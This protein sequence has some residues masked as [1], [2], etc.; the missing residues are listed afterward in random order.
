MTQDPY[1]PHKI[2]H[3]QDVIN[4]L[5][6]NIHVAPIQVQLIISDLCNQ[7]CKFCAYRL[8]NYTSNQLFKTID[9]ITHIINNNPNRMIPKDKCFEIL[10][11]CVEI[12]TKAIQYTGG[13]EPTVHPNHIEIFQK[14]LDLGLDLALVTNG[15]ILRKE[16]PEILSHG[17]WVRISVDCSNAQSYSYIRNVSEKVFYRVL[18]NISC[19][20]KEREK[21]KQSELIIGVGFVVNKDN[22]N[23]IYDAVK[24]S[25]D[26][27][28]DNIRISAAFTVE[29]YHYHDSYYIVARD[30]ARKAKEDFEDSNFKVFNLFGDRIQDLIDQKP[31]YDFCAYMYL[32]TYI[33]GDLNV[34]RCCN[35]A[36]NE[37]GLIGSIKDKRFKDFWFSEDIILKYNSFNATSCERCMFNN[38]NRFINYVLEKKPLHVN[39]I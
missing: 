19:I 4:K 12:G 23:E 2:V 3:H 18:D 17:K 21:N 39:Y 11:D 38:K 35:L 14:T 1:N 9:P 26:L 13:G 34:Y 36:Y 29:N 25:K 32:D 20:I 15:M 6:D 7:N 31:E 33:G 28:V 22:Y 37:K 30:M 8:D 16:L 27:G 24:I 10:N 5:K